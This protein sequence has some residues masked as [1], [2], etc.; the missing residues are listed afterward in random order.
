MTE[1]DAGLPDRPDA[2]PP[3]YHEWPLPAS[4]EVASRVEALWSFRPPARARYCVPPD[5]RIDLVLRAEVASD[6]ALRRVRPVVAGPGLRPAWVPAGPDTRLFGLRFVPG[7]G[8]ACLG[9][10]VATLRDQVWTGARAQALVAA[11]VPALL[12]AT[13]LAGLWPALA[14]AARQLAAAAR[15][16][17]AVQRAAWA[18]ATLAARPG[19]S[20]ADLAQQAGTTPRT[21]RRDV[22]QAIGV[23]LQALLRLQ[24]FHQALALLATR[25]GLALA[26]L[27]QASGYG[28][29]PHLT[30]E[31]RRL[32]GATPGDEAQ[33]QQ[34]PRITLRTAGP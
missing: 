32:C 27:A 18:A 16:R 31:F 20:L 1:P 3:G 7:W 6:G 14:A 28:D 10:P 4:T 33:W 5:G 15:P 23:P 11:R 29:Q 26:D 8:A 17:A 22:A 9:L 24:R 30:R 25:P 2:M 13:D 12:G 21:L 34:L 19:L